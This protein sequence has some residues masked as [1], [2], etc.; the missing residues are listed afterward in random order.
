M[1]DTKVRTL[2]SIITQ[3]LHFSQI[4]ESNESHSA[5]T[6]EIFVVMYI[7]TYWIKKNKK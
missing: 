7:I 2:F 4:P 3:Q 5:S 1:V 6:L